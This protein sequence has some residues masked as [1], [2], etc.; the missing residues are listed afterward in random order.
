LRNRQKLMATDPQSLLTAARCWECF[1]ASRY[2][3]Q[4]MKL[5]LLVN[6]VN[7]N[8]A[9]TDPQSLLAA[10][11]CFMCYASTPYML[12]LM[13][14]ALLAQISNQGGTGGGGQMQIYADGTAPAAIA[15]PS[16]VN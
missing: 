10:A 5:G 6:I 15:P 9:A 16:N 1:G 13:E 8:M 2:Q 7:G 4:L 14:L 3:L 11:K 12:D